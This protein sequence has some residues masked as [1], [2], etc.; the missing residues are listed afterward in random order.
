MKIESHER[1]DQISLLLIRRRRPGEPSPALVRIISMGL[2]VC[3][4]QQQI[5]LLC[6]GWVFL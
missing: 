5:V 3:P 4:L 2:P 6:Q 1:P